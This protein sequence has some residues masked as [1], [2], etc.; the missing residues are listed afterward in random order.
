MPESESPPM[1]T[2]SNNKLFKDEAYRWRWD[3]H[4]K[5]L[6]HIWAPHSYVPPATWPHQPLSRHKGCKRKTDVDT[7]AAGWE[8]H[9]HRFHRGDLVAQYTVGGISFTSTDLIH[10]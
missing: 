9:V 5:G 1:Y 10:L 6:H 3:S 4:A 7:F 8:T 2:V